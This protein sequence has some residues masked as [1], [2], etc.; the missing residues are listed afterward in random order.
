MDA[1]NTGLR[2]F[3]NSA[4]IT[5]SSIDMRLDAQIVPYRQETHRSVGMGVGQRAQTCHSAAWCMGH[6]SY[7]M[8]V[9]TE[10]GNNTLKH[11]QV[12]PEAKKW[13]NTPFVHYND[14]HMLVEG[15]HAT[16]ERAYRVSALSD[17]KPDDATPNE[18]LD[19]V[20]DDDNTPQPTNA[21]SQV[22]WCTH[23]LAAPLVHAERRSPTSY[24]PRAPTLS[25][26][27]PLRHYCPFRR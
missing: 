11:L 14:F 7:G 12:H 9:L 22:S 24:H 2:Y 19:D 25:E 15:R 4:T 13:R 26:P 17:N 23:H 21:T 8:L 3:H 20:G 5:H 10:C 27:Y 16:G 6:L 1:R 18:D